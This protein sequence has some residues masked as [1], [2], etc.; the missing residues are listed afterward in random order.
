MVVHESMF[1]NNHDIPLAQAIHL[2]KLRDGVI[3]T[4][5]CHAAHLLSSLIKDAV[6]EAVGQ[7]IH[8]DGRN[9]Q[10]EQIHVYTQDCHNHTRSIWIGAVTQ[11]MTSYLNK[12]LANDLEAIDF[13]Y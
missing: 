6:T 5:T 12:I 13:R 10:D 2:S 3:T 11:Q 1:D 7:K 9:P 4:D 8:T